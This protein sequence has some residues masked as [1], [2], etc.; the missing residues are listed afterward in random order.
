MKYSLVLFILLFLLSVC[1]D[2]N[3]EILIHFLSVHFSSESLS[4][5]TKMSSIL[6]KYFFFFAGRDNIYAVM[7]N[8]IISVD[9]WF[10]LR[11]G[12]TASEKMEKKKLCTTVVF[13]NIWTSFQQRASL[14]MRSQLRKFLCLI[15]FSKLRKCLTVNT[16]K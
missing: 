11:F 4:Q 5:G 16:S 3:Y 2:R 1:C 10:P 7:M 15:T 9:V 13:F 14:I 6:I 8:Y 12:T